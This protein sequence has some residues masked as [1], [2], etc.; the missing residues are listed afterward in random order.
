[1]EKER[2]PCEY[3]MQVG[4]RAGEKCGKLSPYNYCS[5]HRVKVFS[6]TELRSTMTKMMKELNR[7]TSEL[8][9]RILQFKIPKSDKKLNKTI[10]TI[11]FIQQELYEIEEMMAKVYNEFSNI[12]NT[13]REQCRGL[14]HSQ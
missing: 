10:N 2:F 11:E 8:N 13:F 7:R 1:M 14:R 5:S 3:E 4:K 9:M 12:D 6:E